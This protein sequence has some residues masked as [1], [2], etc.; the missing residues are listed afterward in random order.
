MLQRLYVNVV[1]WD[2]KEK[3]LNFKSEPEWSWLKKEM[4]DIEKKN[5]DRSQKSEAEKKKKTTEKIRSFFL[6]KYPFSDSGSLI[7]SSLGELS[8][9]NFLWYFW[10]NHII[11]PIPHGHRGSL[12]PTLGQSQF[13]F[14]L[15][16]GSGPRGGQHNAS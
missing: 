13:P 12:W 8:F 11:H 14:P 10:S 4:Q 15:A 3:E 6:S 1:C 16:I 2:I 7:P 5:L 9:P